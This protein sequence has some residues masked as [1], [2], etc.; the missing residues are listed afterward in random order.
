[1]ECP[2]IRWQMFVGLATAL[3]VAACDNSTAPGGAG[4]STMSQADVAEAVAGFEDDADVSLG[5]L[6][7]GSTMGMANSTGGLAL[8]RDPGIPSLACIVVEP[9][10]PEDPDGDG[11]PTRLSVHFDP[12]P[13]EIGLGRG[14][15][16]LSGSL[17]IFDPTPETA[18]YD[19]VEE[20]TNFGFKL[21]LAER[22]YMVVR[23]GRRSVSQEGSVLTADELL[24]GLHVVNGEREKHSRVDWTLRFEGESTIGYL[25]PLPSGALTINGSWAWT[26]GDRERVF[27]VETVTP[28]Q[29][30]AT[31][32]DVRPIHRFTAGEIHKV[33]MVNGQT[34]GTL[35]LVWT[36]CGERPART[37]VPSGDQPTDH[38]TDG[39]D[40]PTDGGTI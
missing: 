31:C 34:R 22:S 14:T 11:I 9:N 24:E 20:L 39:G 17:G 33:L 10:P 29:Y 1:M 28:L 4:A 21:S 6:F 32:A 30:D 15:V 37:F 18:G 35:I 19:I 12:D 36:G 27:G 3:T 16:S 5:A 2:R 38:P 8:S 26:A 23:S 7:S 13:C 25:Q 40:Q